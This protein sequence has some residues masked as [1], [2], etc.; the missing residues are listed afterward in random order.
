MAAPHKFTRKLHEAIGSEAAEAMADWMN[1]SDMQ[2][3][4]LQHEVAE[5]RHEVRADFAE[6]RQEMNARFAAVEAKMSVGF[7]AVDSRFAA[8]EAKFAAA[9]A[10]AER[11]HA[12]FMR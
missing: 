2:F 11:R 10:A 12:D 6:L 9:E 4:G 5:F 1:Q 8:V 3:A 7:A